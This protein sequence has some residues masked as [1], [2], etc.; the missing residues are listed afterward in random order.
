MHGLVSTKTGSLPPSDQRQKRSIAAVRG[1][2]VRLRVALRRER[3]AAARPGRVVRHVHG[4]AGARREGDDG[5]DEGRRPP[6]SP[7]SGP[8]VRERQD[9]K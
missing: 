6:A 3:H 5:V 4:D 8:I 1:D 7:G 2:R 9:G